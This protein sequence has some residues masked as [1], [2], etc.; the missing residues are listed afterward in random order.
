MGQYN[1]NLNNRGS[2]HRQEV[3]FDLFFILTLF[4]K[5]VANKIDLISQDNS[6]EESF[7]VYP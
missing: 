3:I 6:F 2:H 1:V 4:E 5:L 7:N